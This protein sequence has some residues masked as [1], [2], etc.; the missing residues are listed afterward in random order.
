MQEV[1]LRVRGSVQGVGFRAQVQRIARSLSIKGW[2]R[3]ERD[4]SV[5]ALAQGDGAGIEKFVFRIANIHDPFG[6]DVEKVELEQKKQ[7][8]DFATHADFLIRY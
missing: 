7:I 1:L 6:A 2:V 4:G 5:S 3:N 8:G